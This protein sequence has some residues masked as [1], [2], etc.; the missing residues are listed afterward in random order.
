[1]KGLVTETNSSMPAVA[2][3]DSLTKAEPYGTEEIP[4]SERHGHPRS[5]FTLWFAANMVLAVLVSGFFASSFG[6]SIA[7]GLSAVFVGSFVGVLVMGILAGVGARFGVAQQVQARGPMGY[8][9]NFIPVAL[10]TNVSAI[11]WV[12]V[13]TVFAVIALQQLIDVPFWLGSLVMFALQALFA[14]WGHN[15]IHLVNKIATVVLTV[16]FAIITVLALTRVDV[17]ASPPAAEGG[18][19]AE[20]I[21]F[22]GFFFIYVMTWT[23]FASDFSR[24]LPRKSSETAIVFYTAAGGFLSL[25]WLGSIGVLVASFAGDLGAV[26]AVAELTGSW[27]WI[28]MITVV[29]ST[30][31]VSAMNLYGGALSLLTIRVPVTRTV[32][33]IITAVISFVVTL[34]MQEDPYGSFYDFLMLL[35][36]LVV[37]FSTVLLLDYFIRTKRRSAASVTELFDSRRTV[38]WGFIAWLIGCLVSS[39]FWTTPLGTGPLAPLIE[40]A[41]DVTYYI[42]AA[43]AAVAY[44]VIHLIRRGNPDL[45]MFSLGGSASVDRGLTDP[46]VADTEQEEIR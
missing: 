17:A 40:D 1:M 44:L 24:Y 14:M 10:L 13:N 12:A 8:F 18:G 37:P 2:Y 32:G 3:G 6:L 42:G 28:A 29:L 34:I 38:A 7:Q 25:A 31:P 22:A 21:T 4:D 20:W 30:I 16:L 9:G 15:L 46:V 39:L 19:L 35:G 27:S 36:Y 11:G 45:T 26:E 23:P 43:A 41:G 33:V 5:Q